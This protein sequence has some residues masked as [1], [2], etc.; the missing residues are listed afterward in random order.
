MSDQ[1]TASQNDQTEDKPAVASKPM[2]IG[3][4]YGQQSSLQRGANPYAG[5][6][7]PGFAGSPAAAQRSESSTDRRLVI[8]QG[9]TMSGEIE[10][11]DHLLV[12]GTI[13]AALKG[14][15][16]LEISETGTFRGTVEIKNA[17][18]A[19]RFEGDLTVDGRLVLKAGG[20][21]TG[22]ISY[23]ELQIEA[24]A[25]IDG[26]LTPLRGQIQS[27]DRPAAKGKAS[28]PSAPKASK[29]DNQSPANTD[30]Q[31]FA[32]AGAAE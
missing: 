28:I 18:I 22:S 27:E 19:G 9:I 20:V 6:G 30:G 24:G 11:C 2:D 10:S 15:K 32:E 23:R 31:L 14:A 8:G 21:I 12:E 5:G 13:E 25:I 7:Y 16:V 29:A 4:P 3:S 1:N 26:R 17:T